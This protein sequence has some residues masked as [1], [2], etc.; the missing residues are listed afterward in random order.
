MRERHEPAPDERRRQKGGKTVRPRRETEGVPLGDVLFPPD[1][2]CGRRLPQGGGTG[3]QRVFSA[4][5]TGRQA[6]E[7]CAW[8][9]LALRRALTASR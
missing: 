8:R 6:R 1:C 9:S 3:R 2:A 5:V 7:A 4:T